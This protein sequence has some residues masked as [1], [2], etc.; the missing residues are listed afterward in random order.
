MKFYR[1]WLAHLRPVE[2]GDEA[3]PHCESP[4]MLAKH[5]IETNYSRGKSP[6]P[7]MEFFARSGK[8]VIITSR[9]FIRCLHR[10]FW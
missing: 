6:L 1:V 9:E 4:S 10:K 8:N 7:N 5:A 2:A 3:S